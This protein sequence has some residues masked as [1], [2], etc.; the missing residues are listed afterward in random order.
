MGRR[1]QT[2]RPLESTH[3]AL[4]RKSVKD[5]KR[6]FREED[7]DDLSDASARSAKSLKSLM[8]E[9]TVWIKAKN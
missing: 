2:I 4:Q 8:S 1:T 9:A 3:A 5:A 6:A 7:G